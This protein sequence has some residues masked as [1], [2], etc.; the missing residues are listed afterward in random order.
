MYYGAFIEAV[1]TCLC[2]LASRAISDSGMRFATAVDSFVATSLVVAGK[3]IIIPHGYNLQ[4]VSICTN[5]V[6]NKL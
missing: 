5:N 1:A 3:F 2:R 4:T 6:S